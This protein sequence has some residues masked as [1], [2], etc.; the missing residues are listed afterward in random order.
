MLLS[1]CC[2]IFN[3]NMNSYLFSLGMRRLLKFIVI[4]CKIFFVREVVVCFD[5]Y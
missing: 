2:E 1:F 4:V 3:Y 5:V